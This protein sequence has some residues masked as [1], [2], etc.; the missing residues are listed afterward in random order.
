[1]S[2][3][4]HC[5]AAKQHP[6]YNVEDKSEGINGLRELERDAFHGQDDDTELKIARVTGSLGWFRSN[7]GRSLS[8]V[9]VCIAAIAVTLLSS[10]G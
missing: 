1:M 5:G 3:M 9:I 2:M 10:G 7:R 8:C 6:G 4:T